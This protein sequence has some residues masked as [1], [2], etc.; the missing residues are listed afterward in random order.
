MLGV[1]TSWGGNCDVPGEEGDLGLPGN[2]EG[3]RERIP[4]AWKDGE[5][6]SKRDDACGFIIGEAGSGLFHA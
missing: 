4:D 3:E 2:G 5:P 1:V 6:P